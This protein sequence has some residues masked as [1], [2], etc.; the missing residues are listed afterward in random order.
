MTDMQGEKKTFSWKTN[1][2]WFVW[3]Y[4]DK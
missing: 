3:K 2:I 1:I 4:N